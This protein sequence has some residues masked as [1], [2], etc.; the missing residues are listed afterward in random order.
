MAIT[1]TR[2]KDEWIALCDN[3]LETAIATCSNTTL[4]PA[5]GVTATRKVTRAQTCKMLARRALRKATQGALRVEV[6][7][8][9]AV[10]PGA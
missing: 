8:S 2:T 6:L 5:S 3:A 1:P 4:V 9:P 7:T 10:T